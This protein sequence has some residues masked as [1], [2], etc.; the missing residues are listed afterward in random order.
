MDQ[1]LWYR[2]DLTIMAVKPLGKEWMAN[3][4]AVVRLYERGRI[5]PERIIIH[6]I[7]LGE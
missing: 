4:E 6:R 3:M 7:G 2:H 5:E 1:S